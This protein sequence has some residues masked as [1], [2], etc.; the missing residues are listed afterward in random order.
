[1]VLPDPEW[2]VETLET[3]NGDVAFGIVQEDAR[4]KADTSPLTFGIDDPTTDTL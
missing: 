2:E 4:R 1:M 3:D